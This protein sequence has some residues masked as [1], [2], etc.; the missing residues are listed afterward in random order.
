MIEEYDKLSKYSLREIKKI[1]EKLDFKPVM[2]GGWAVHFHINEELLRV[3]G[4]RYIGS[5]DIDLGV[6]T[7]AEYRKIT[8]TLEKLGY[9]PLSFRY[10]KILDYETGK[11]ATSSLPL[12]RLFYIFVDIAVDNKRRVAGRTVLEEPL[13]SEIVNKEGYT[14]KE[15][16]KLPDPEYCMAMKIK[17]ASERAGEKLIKDQIDMILLYAFTSLNLDFLQ[18]LVIRENL[19]NKIRDIV[20]RINSKI[21][22]NELRILRFEASE[23]ENLV[24]TFRI[25]IKTLSE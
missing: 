1:M 21:L 16:F 2:M 6:T 5:K 10:Y 22:V 13:L 7:S 25:S 20:S 9:K 8:E 19:K 3:K 14:L 15:K 24:A 23:A 18:E 4:R 17:A 12:Y 11:P